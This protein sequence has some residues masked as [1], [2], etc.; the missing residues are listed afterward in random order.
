MEQSNTV[1]MKTK[2][3]APVPI[4][5]NLHSS[6][7]HGLGLNLS[8]DGQFRACSPRHKVLQLML[9][10]DIFKTPIP[11]A[12]AVIMG[13][14]TVEKVPSSHS[15]LGSISANKSTDG[16][17][18]TNLHI[19]ELANKMMETLRKRTVS[20]CESACCQMKFWKLEIWV[21]VSRRAGITEAWH[22]P[23]LQWQQLCHLS[24]H[25]S[26]HTKTHAKCRACC[27]LVLFGF[28]LFY[29]FYMYGHFACICMCVCVMHHM[30]AWYHR[31]QKG[32]RIPGTPITLKSTKGS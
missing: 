27:L 3:P 32:Y 13:T 9:G 28:L 24:M 6:K 7:G 21:V 20:R 17:C 31:N 14:L 15:V 12:L 23:W 29:L 8:Y 18:C 5:F 19:G 16:K 22:N 2:L 1:G 25:Y 4:S 26:W 30:H 11:V 10:K